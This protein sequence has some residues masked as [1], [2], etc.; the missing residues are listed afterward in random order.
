M[1][2]RGQGPPPLPDEGGGRQRADADEGG[3]PGDR[4]AVDA[5]GEGVRRGGRRAARHPLCGMI[6]LGPPRIPVP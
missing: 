3:R 2:G 1:Q 4:A 6:R 5:L